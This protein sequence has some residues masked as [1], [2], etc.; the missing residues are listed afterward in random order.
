MMLAGLW[1]DA[2]L[3][4]MPKLCLDVRSSTQP[5]PTY[6]LPQKTGADCLLLTTNAGIQPKL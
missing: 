4:L 1:L 6:F 5:S 3:Q 2:N